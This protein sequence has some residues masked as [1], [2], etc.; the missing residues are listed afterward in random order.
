MRRSTLIVVVMVLLCATATQAQ[1]TGTRRATDRGK[2]ADPPRTAETT[3]EIDP[4]LL[5]AER[6]PSGLDR[7]VN[8][9]TYIIGPADRFVLYIRASEEL[10]IVVTVLPEGS[11]LLPNVGPLRAAGLTI[12]EFRA[13]LRK[14]LGRYYRNVDIHCQL[15]SPRAFIVYVLGEVE[16]PGAVELRSPFRIDA[17]IRAAGGLT[18]QGS[19]RS[20]EIRT[21]ST[22]VRRVDM[23]RFLR[24]GDM[25]ENPVLSEGQSVYVPPRGT[26]CTII[27]E[28]WHGGVYEVHA[29]ETVQDIVDLA[30]GYTATAALDRVVVERMGD[31]EQFSVIQIPP[32]ELASTLVRLRDVIVIPD[33]RTFPGTRSVRVEG[34]QGREGRVF[35]EEGETIGNFVS[36][37]VRLSDNHDLRNAVVERELADGSIEFIPVDL[38]RV[39]SGAD[40]GELVLQPGDVISV[41]LVDNLVYVT[42]EVT[43]PGAVGFQRGLPAARYIALAGGPSQRGSID[44]LE[45]FDAEGR[46][47]SGNR[48]SLVYRGETILVRTKKS[49][50]FTTLFFGFTSL[51]GLMIAVIALANTQ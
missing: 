36:R 45:I 2:T 21:D 18:D 15:I 47:R 38:T 39:I 51:A 13:T 14:A 24:L 37:F 46:K 30:G 19:S 6:I 34:G 11:V 7:P 26:F 40:P 23:Q 3:T 4:R 27:G 50:I 41:P 1:R 32:S 16:N 22:T 17:A 48:D 12:T 49:V 35:I 31:A 43:E 10:E 28:I 29:G 42:G 25:T 44:R 33:K 9:D 20:M 8:P 5:E